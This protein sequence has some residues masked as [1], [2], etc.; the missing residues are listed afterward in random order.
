MKTSR[1]WSVTLLKSHKKSSKGRLLKNLIQSSQSSNSKIKQNITI[2]RNIIHR[3]RTSKERSSVWR[4]WLSFY[5]V[6]EQVVEVAIGHPKHDPRHNNSCLKL[7]QITTSEEVEV[8]QTS[9][10]WLISPS[11]LSRSLPRAKRSEKQ[12][13][14]LSQGLNRMRTLLNCSSQILAPISSTN[15]DIKT[16][17]VRVDSNKDQRRRLKVGGQISKLLCRYPLMERP[18]SLNHLHNRW[19]LDATIR[20]S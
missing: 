19:S 11:N 2:R 13:I 9:K 12:L 8:L 16:S 17:R 5:P 10:V 4:S 1:V 18:I 15:S 20:A 14:T 7:E 3:S 6:E